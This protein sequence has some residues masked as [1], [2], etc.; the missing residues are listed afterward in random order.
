[1][2]KFLLVVSFILLWGGMAQ[3]ENQ[4]L[5]AQLSGRFL[6]DGAAYISSPDTLDSQVNIGDLRLCGK[7]SVGD[8]WSVMLDVAFT[9][10]KL[11]IKDAFLQYLKHGHGVKVGYF[12]G[13]FGIKRLDGFLR[14]CFSHGSK[15]YGGSLCRPTNGVGLLA[16]STEIFS[17]LGYVLL[18]WLHE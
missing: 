1:M 4:K 16:Y 14:L 15:C 2:K 17:V 13:S 10:N 12:H 9:R 5:K 6:L 7:A 3:A 8:S 18:G 11:S